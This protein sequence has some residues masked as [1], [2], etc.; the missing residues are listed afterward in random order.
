MSAAEYHQHAS[1]RPVTSDQALNA[2]GSAVTAQRARND[3]GVEGVRHE[4]WW[5]RV[6]DV[7]LGPLENNL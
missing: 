5:D 3:V 4:P 7:C 6:E 2:L 1:Q